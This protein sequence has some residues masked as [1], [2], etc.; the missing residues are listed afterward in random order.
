M[1]KTNWY[2]VF[3]NAGLS[4]YIIAP[5]A[6]WIYVDSKMKGM[7]KGIHD[8]LN[9]IKSK[10]KTLA[11]IPKKL[12][13]FHCR[14]HHKYSFIKV[15]F[16]YFLYISGLLCNI[17]SMGPIIRSKASLSMKSNLLFV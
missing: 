13:W 9:R 11:D 3:R 4:M 16:M 2:K 12:D 10:G 14:H 5:I 17:V 15:G 7:E 6:G 8:D 1:K